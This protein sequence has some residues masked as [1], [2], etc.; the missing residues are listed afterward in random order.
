MS[1]QQTTPE[2]P[3]EIDH[4]SIHPAKPDPFLALRFRDYRLFIIGRILLFIGYQVRTVAVGWELY[5]RTGSAMALGGIGL[6]QVVPIIL[7]TL[8]AG[9]LADQW[10]RKHIL[11]LTTLV[12]GLTTLGLAVISATHG[13]IWLIYLCLFIYGI[14]R[15]FN[16]PA[17]DALGWQLIPNYAFTN[18]ATWNS[19]SF[20]IAAVSGPALGGIAIAVMGTATGAYVLA[21]TAAFLCF[22]SVL[23]IADQPTPGSTE[24]LSLKALSAGV[25]FVWQNQLILA[26]ITLDLF[27]VLLGGATALLPLFAKDILHVGPVALGWLQ[28]APSIGAIAM[29]FILAYRPPFRQ[30]GSAL[31]WSVVGFGIATVVFGISHSFWLSLLMLMLIGA[32]DNIS[33]VIRHTLVQIRT[34]ND[35]RGR[36]AA[37]NGV[38]IS[39]SNELGAFESGLTAALWGPVLSV[40]LGG[41]GTIAVVLG[42]IAIFPKIRQ[43][44]ALND[45]E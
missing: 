11:L 29:A 41:I 17:S 4:H 20:Q 16:K 9:H 14:A 24:R 1:Q 36:V 10:H 18:A 15:A 13:S 23:L 2:A 45:Y 25:R 19:G 22:G 6:V 28:S 5:D 31:L 30:A 40:V 8:F 21:A 33:V 34:P 44:G 42:A 38:F 12:I 35:L 3:T 39:A 32:L 27:A 7:L 37:I 26:A 43:L